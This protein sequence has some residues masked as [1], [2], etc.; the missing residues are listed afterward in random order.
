MKGR[1]YSAGRMLADRLAIP[2]LCTGITLSIGG[3]YIIV[4]NP[5]R[6][7]EGLSQSAWD[8]G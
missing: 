4:F 3:W 1:Q 6:S 8:Y 7:L 5:G 2:K